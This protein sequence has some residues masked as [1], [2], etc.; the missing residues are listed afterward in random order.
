M[1]YRRLVLPAVTLAYWTLYLVAVLEAVLYHERLR[2]LGPLATTGGFVG[3]GLLALTLR[4]WRPAP[5]R[6]P[7][8]YVA[9]VQR[10]PQPWIPPVSDRPAVTLWERLTAPG[11]RGP[12]DTTQILEQ[13]PVRA[14]AVAE[15]EPKPAPPDVD[16]PLRV[17]DFGTFLDVREEGYEE[18]YD[19]G[20]D[21]GQRGRPHRKASGDK[22]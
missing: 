14:V 9:P 4:L 15:A 2:V 12:N 18:G 7:Q 19:V 16:E 5:K 21:D 20:Y 22:D 3:L 10:L 11:A 17:R 8:P 6:A 1:P 13:L